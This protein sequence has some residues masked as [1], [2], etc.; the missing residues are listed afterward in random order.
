M[1]KFILGVL[2]GIAG[3]IGTC[4]AVDKFETEKNLNYTDDD[5]ASRLAIPAIRL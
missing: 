5:S 3:T 1:H 2:V 4:L